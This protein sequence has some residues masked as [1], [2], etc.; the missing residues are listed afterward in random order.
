MHRLLSRFRL[1]ISP[2]LVRIDHKAGHGF[3]KATT[4]LVKEQADIYAFIMYNLGMKMKY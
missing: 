1:K 4:K 2:T 3:N